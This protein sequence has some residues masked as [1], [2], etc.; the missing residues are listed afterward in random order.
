MRAHGSTTTPYVGEGYRHDGGEGDGMQHIRFIPTL[1]K[2]GSYEVNLAFC[3]LGNRASN[4]TVI[5]R[6]AEGETKLVV[7]Q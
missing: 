6:H 3:A 5:V 7:N 2:A 4:A 1:E